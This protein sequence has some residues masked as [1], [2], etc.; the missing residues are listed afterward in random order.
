MISSTRFALTGPVG[1]GEKDGCVP[2]VPPFERL[3][4]SNVLFPLPAHTCEGCAPDPGTTTTPS[5][6][7]TAV[8]APIGR[9]VKTPLL[10]PMRLTY[11]FVLAEKM[12][13]EAFERSAT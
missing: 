3:N 2:V 7:A 10:P 1:I 12:S 8:G 11:V 4:A 13:I 9:P 6:P 5:G